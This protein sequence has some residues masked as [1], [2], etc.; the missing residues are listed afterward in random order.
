MAR[1][2]LTDKSSRMTRKTARKTSLEKHQTLNRNTGIIVPIVLIAIV[3]YASWVVISLV[4]AQYLIHG[5]EHFP[6]HIHNNRTGAGIAVIVLYFVLLFAPAVSYFRLLDSVRKPGYVPKAEPVDTEH[7]QY[8]EK[9]HHISTD[10]H[11]SQNVRDSHLTNATSFTLTEIPH[12]IV[13]ENPHVSDIKESADTPE[14]CEETNNDMSSNPAS[15]THIASENH[16]IRSARSTSMENFTVSE[17]SPSPAQD[18]RPTSSATQNSIGAHG[19]KVM[20]L[21]MEAI[22]KGEV[23]APPGLEQFYQRDTFI[24][25]SI[26]FPIWCGTCS[27][28]KPDR[29]H[30]CSDAGKCVM[31][32][33]HFCPWV[34]GVVGERNFKFFIQFTSYTCIYTLFILIT[35]ACLIHDRSSH[36]IGVNA[37]WIV[38]LALSAIFTLFTSTMAGT[39]IELAVKNRTTIEDIGHDRRTY[40]VAVYLNEPGKYIQQQ[41]QEH[42]PSPTTR[43]PSCD[44]GRHY[45]VAFSSESVAAPASSPPALPSSQPVGPSPQPPLPADDHVGFA[46]GECTRLMLRGSKP[47]KAASTATTQ[48]DSAPKSPWVGTITYPLV[49]RGPLPSRPLPPPRTFAVLLTRPGMNLWNVGASGNWRQVMGERWW[50]WFLPSRHSPCCRHDRDDSLYELGPDMDKLKMEAGL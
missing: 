48:A 14:H 7:H 39:S 36:G 11:H 37:N 15:S 19:Q 18:Q 10:R 35:M 24:C 44:S 28:Y 43:S 16:T 47:E 1:S 49:L 33:D 41:Q 32:L 27:N 23:A 42:L 2:F 12:E 34:G 26:G 38:V 25:D 40:H 50:D 20:T 4:A 29:T 9:N 3:V 31:K 6:N 13:S 17:N 21:D 8:V 30:H 46:P 5:K 22:F 45:Q